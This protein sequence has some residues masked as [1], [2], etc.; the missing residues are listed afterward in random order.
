MHVAE[1][2]TCRINACSLRNPGR[3]TGVQQGHI[4]GSFAYAGPVSPE[5]GRRVPVCPRSGPTPS[6][7]VARR[8]AS[9][10]E[11]L[12]SSSPYEVNYNVYINSFLILRRRV[13][14]V[15]TGPD[16]PSIA[17]SYSLPRSLSTL[18]PRRGRASSVRM[19]PTHGG[20]WEDKKQMQRH[21]YS[22]GGLSSSF[23]RSFDS[24]NKYG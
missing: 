8:R 21:G 16:D 4:E 7:E 24:Q 22:N 19:L 15:A 6:F 14:N 12:V 2:N 10:Y 23:G 9:V 3:F 5:A 13:I 20:A 11:P 17:Q 18:K 1:E